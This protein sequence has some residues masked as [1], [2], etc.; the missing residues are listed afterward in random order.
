MKVQEMYRCNCGAEGLTVDV[1]KEDKE[2]NIAFWY[3]DG[4]FENRKLGLRE[5]IRWTWNLFKTGNP[6]TDMVILSYPVARA[7]AKEILFH[8]G[9]KQWFK[10]KEDK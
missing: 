2:V 5:K 7:L 6:Y 3:Q 8:T 9:N 1:D 4:K 10:K